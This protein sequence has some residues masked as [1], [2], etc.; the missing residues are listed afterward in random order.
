[1]KLTNTSSIGEEPLGYCV[2]K[3]CS[4]YGIKKVVEYKIIASKLFTLM[5]ANKLGE[6]GMESLIKNYKQ[7][8][9]KQDDD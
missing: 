6:E 2:N 4:F 1:M 5:Q 9:V 7:K 8:G 3:K